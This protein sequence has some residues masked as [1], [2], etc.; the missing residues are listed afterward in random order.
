MHQA[1]EAPGATT[2]A[3]PPVTAGLEQPEFDDAADTEVT[4][5][6]A[7]AASGKLGTPGL[8][9]RFLRLPVVVLVVHNWLAVVLQVRRPVHHQQHAAAPAP[10]CIMNS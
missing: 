10:D 6:Q 7:P 1:P 8:S 2:A 3:C 9:R 5:T 4:I